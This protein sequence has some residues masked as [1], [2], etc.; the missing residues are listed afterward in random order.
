MGG[1]RVGYAIGNSELIAALRQV[2]AAVDFNQYRGILNGSDLPISNWPL[3]YS[4]NQ[5][6][7][8]QKTAGCLCKSATGHWAASTRTRGHHVRL[9]STAGTLG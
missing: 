6:R 8:L 1:F 3:R 5:R 2:K 4:Q 7:N 9:G